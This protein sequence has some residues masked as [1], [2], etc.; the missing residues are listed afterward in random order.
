MAQ[1]TV[2]Q[3]SGPPGRGPSWWAPA[4]VAGPAVQV[5]VD[6]E[7]PSRGVRGGLGGI[8]AFRGWGQHGRARRRPE[9]NKNHLAFVLAP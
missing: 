1:G 7:C 9:G 6:A 3:A 8:P 5:V 2:G 4:A